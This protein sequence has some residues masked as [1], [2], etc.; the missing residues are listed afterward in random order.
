MAHN[1]KACDEGRRIPV[2]SA[3]PA[4]H[5]RRSPARTESHVSTLAARIELPPTLPSVRA[6]RHLVVHL[7]QA[8]R[9][10]H[11]VDD[12]ALLVT[13][14][15]ANV[16]DHVGGEASLA[17]E[18][19]LSGG[20]LRI[21]VADGSSVP[22][23]VRELDMHSPRGRGMRLVQAIADRWGSEDRDGGKR[24]WLELAPPA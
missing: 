6:A 19:Q 24:V 8:W 15:V 4:R 7:L 14:L 22:P 11:D 2:P 16:V 20:R 9:A 12:A 1:R 17:V 5:P 13:E 21:A 23:V 3:V 18:L 10:P